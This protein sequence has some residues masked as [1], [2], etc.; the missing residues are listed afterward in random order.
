MSQTYHKSAVMLLVGAVSLLVTAVVVEFVGANVG[1]LEGA[2]VESSAMEGDA[3]VVPFDGPSMTTGEV[4]GAADSCPVATLGDEDGR[5]VGS[6]EGR[7]VVGPVGDFVLFFVGLRLVGNGVVGNR[8]GD[9][10]GL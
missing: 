4:D 7:M 8:V 10:D 1:E 6:L 9:F 5:I 3:V 2:V